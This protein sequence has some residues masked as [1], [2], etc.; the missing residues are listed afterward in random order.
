[1]LMGVNATWIWMIGYL[2]GLGFMC[3]HVAGQPIAG[4]AAYVGSFVLAL[5]VADALG[6]SATT[7]EAAQ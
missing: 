3:A 2:G 6:K 5:V 4:W 7:D 1:M